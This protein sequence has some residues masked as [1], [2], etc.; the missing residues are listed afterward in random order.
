LPAS[1]T[2]FKRSIEWASKDDNTNLANHLN[3]NLD[4]MFVHLDNCRGKNLLPRNSAL[5]CRYFTEGSPFLRLAPLKMEQLN[6]E[7][8][9]GLFHDVISPEEQDD[10]INLS[11]SRLEHRKVDSSSVE[12]EVPVNAS[13]H[14][15]RIHQRIEDMTGLN[16]GESNPI[17]VSNFGIGG[18]DF[19]HLDCEQPKV[20]L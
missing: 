11:T 20:S 7:P 13:D 14:V 9:V 6:F 8:F 4:H 5:R 1:Q 12:A 18:Q 19:I 17:T 15:A 10:L 2:A 16:L 3:D